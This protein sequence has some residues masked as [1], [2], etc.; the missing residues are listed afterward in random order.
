MQCKFKG[1]NL[2]FKSHEW[3][4]ILYEV[5]ILRGNQTIPQ[6]GR[7]IKSLIMQCVF[8]KTLGQPDKW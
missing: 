2:S 5:R 6:K 3:S 1:G 8:W 7:H 4:N